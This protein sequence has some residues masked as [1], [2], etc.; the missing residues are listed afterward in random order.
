[1]HCKYFYSFFYIM[2]LFLDFC[3]TCSIFTF[4]FIYVYCYTP[5]HSR[6]PVCENLLGK[7]VNTDSDLVSLLIFDLSTYLSLNKNYKITSHFSFAAPEKEQVQRRNNLETKVRCNNS[8]S[9]KNSICVC[10]CVCSGAA[11]QRFPTTG[12]KP[13]ASSSCMTAPQ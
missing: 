11:N 4:L 10:V 9:E 12:T 8:N 1:M 2:F 5:I 13:A 3:S 6:F 7:K